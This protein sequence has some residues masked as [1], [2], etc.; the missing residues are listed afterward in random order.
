[1]ASFF[2]VAQ[3]SN[4]IAESEKGS[5][6]VGPLEISETFLLGVNILSLWACQ[7][8]QWQFADEDSVFCFLFDCN[9]YDSVRPWGELVSFGLCDYSASVAKF[10]QSLGRSGGVDLKVW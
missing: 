10:N 2:L 9:L 1:M 7:I 3:N 8:D 6:Y 4:A 5:V